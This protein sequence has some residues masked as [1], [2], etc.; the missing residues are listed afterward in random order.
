MAKHKGANRLGLFEYGGGGRGGAGFR[1]WNS[2]KTGKVLENCS[3]DLTSPE[4]I[5]RDCVDP[6]AGTEEA[7]RK[8]SLIRVPV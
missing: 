7:L 5:P 1:T 6:S 4:V 2:F 3:S 8:Y